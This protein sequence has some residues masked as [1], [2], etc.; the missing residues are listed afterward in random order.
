MDRCWLVPVEGSAVLIRDFEG[1][2]GKYRFEEM[3]ALD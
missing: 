3:S 2:W 1:E